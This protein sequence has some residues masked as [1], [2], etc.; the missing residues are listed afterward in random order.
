MEFTTPPA[1]A[2]VETNPATDISQQGVTLHGEFDGNGLPT[3]YYF[4]YGPTTAY[5]LVSEAAP[6]SAAGS[7]VGPTAVSSVIDEYEGYSTYHFRLVAVN[8]FGETRG[9]DQSFETLAAPLPGVENPAVVNLAPTSATLM[10]EVNPNRWPTVYL[11]EW[12]RSTSYGSS[13][14]ISTAIGGLGNVN[15]PVSAPVTGLAPATTYHFRVVATNF[16]GTTNGPDYT[17]ST[18]DAPTVE[19]SF[20]SATGQSSAHFGARVVANSKPTAVHFE[21]G[22]TSAYGLSTVPAQ[23]GSGTIASAAG[24]D[25]T[26]LTPGT[27]YHYRAVA[28]NSVGTT[29]GPDQTLST[30]Q[31]GSQPPPPGAGCAALERRAK[32]NSSRAKRLSRRAAGSKSPS[33]ARALRRK[34]SQHAR[35]AKSLRRKAAACAGGGGDVR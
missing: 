12:G 3:S 18:P 20:G 22:T 6:G 10:A 19:S 31:A 13:T 14:V 9:P 7:P 17:F 29:Y 26:G 15:L 27:T 5:G 28:V 34:A 4:E 21:Y 2:G 35:R 8:S 30:D 11:F 16:T 24:A 23:I 1:V 33:R 25:V 32:A